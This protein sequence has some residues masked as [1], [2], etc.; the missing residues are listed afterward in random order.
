MKS[1]SKPQLLVEVYTIYQNLSPDEE[2]SI[3]R[4]F[5]SKTPWFLGQNLPPFCPICEKV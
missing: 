3:D 4:P 5:R 1:I 2:E